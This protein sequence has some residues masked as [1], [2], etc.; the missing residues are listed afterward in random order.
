M[1]LPT[2]AVSALPVQRVH[3][4]ALEWHP[5]QI[6]MR[7]SRLEYRGSA[8]Y[9][10]ALAA[11][12]PG[13]TPVR[14]LDYEILPEQ[15]GVPER[16]AVWLLEGDGGGDGWQRPSKLSPEDRHWAEQA[17]T[18]DPPRRPLWQRRGGWA[19]LLSWLDAELLEQGLT[20]RGVP[21]VLKDWGIS[22]LARVDTDHGTVY[23]KAVPDFFRAE[24]GVT[25][26]L[27]REL[28]GAAA[29]LLAADTG[30][31]LMLLE[32]AG[33]VLHNGASGWFTPPPD[34]PAWTEADSHALMR[35]LAQVQRGAEGQPWLREL[36]DHGP[37]W[38]LG[39]LP[40]L[41][42]GPLFLIGEPGGLTPEEGEALS[43]LRPRLE[44]ALERLAA[45][46][47]PRTLGHGDLHEGNVARHQGRFTLLDWSDASRTHP[48]LDGAVP[49]LVPAAHR[50]EAADAYLAAWSELLPLSE[51]RQLMQDGVL[52]GEL[53]RVLGITEGIQP[54]VG[55][56][57]WHTEHLEHFR[58]LL[59]R[60]A[61]A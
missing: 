48:F 10:P 5:D 47:V 42:G 7:L 56:G 51:L 55:D 30:R 40:R 9:G 60:A 13:A 15:G 38:V 29:R 59:R 18:P 49:Y 28:A 44:A 35:H 43:A 24:V 50:L 54:H 34:A 52:A 12:V 25:A 16:R 45:S 17:L 58:A 8:Y 3:L 61:P 26:A 46:P 33:E 20:R 39:H 14:R 22:F 27:G 53:Y 41:L 4:T 2:Q 6:R 31:G 19:E 37:E 32:H 11:A 23:L 1:T 21:Q 36:P 57:D